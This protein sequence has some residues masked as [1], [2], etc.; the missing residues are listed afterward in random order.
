MET[1]IPKCGECK[2]TDI[3]LV[4]MDNENRWWRIK[5]VTCLEA[6]NFKD[7]SSAG[8]YIFEVY[9]DQHGFETTDETKIVCTDC[10]AELT[11]QEAFLGI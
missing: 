10:G 8:R 1:R 6:I 5:T 7:G 9:N 4:D 3:K 11:D 2:G